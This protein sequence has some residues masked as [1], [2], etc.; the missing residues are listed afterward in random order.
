MN[1]GKRL[2]RARKLNGFNK[3]KQLCEYLAKK[4][5][6]IPYARL[7]SLERNETEPT[8][9]ETNILCDELRISAD[10][11]LRENSYSE[12]ALIRLV[13]ELTPEDRKLAFM[14]LDCLKNK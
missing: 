1:P 10:W 5:K 13:G 4:D 6:K 12:R 11:Y 3:R 14:Y 9:T 7:G 2:T 8:I